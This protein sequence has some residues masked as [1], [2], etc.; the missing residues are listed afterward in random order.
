MAFEH[1]CSRDDVAPGTMAQFV[2]TD[3]TRVLVVAAPG[4]GELKAY[5]AMCPHA[6]VELVAGSLD[7]DILTCREHWWQFDIRTGQGTNP[8]GCHLAAY[9]LVCAG[10]AVLVDVAG[11]EPA[12]AGRSDS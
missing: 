1:L 11:I 4:D 2:T 6:R 10:D 3:G 5:Q 9:P 8:T 12:Q 7:G